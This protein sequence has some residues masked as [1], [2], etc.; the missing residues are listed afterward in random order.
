M[1]VIYD[2]S[3]IFNNLPF[4]FTAF[5]FLSLHFKYYCTGFLYENFNLYSVVKR[6]LLIMFKYFVL[7]DDK[8]G[9]SEHYARL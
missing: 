1:G 5:H 4:C 8:I 3:I 7:F 2:S 6:F 9:F